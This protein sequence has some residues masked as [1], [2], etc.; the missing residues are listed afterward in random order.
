MY[1]LLVVDDEPLVRRGILAFVDFGRLQIEKV[2]EAANGAEALEIFKREPVDL[3]LA[4]INMPKMNGLELAEAMKKIRPVKI[5]LVTG[6]DYFDYAVKALKTGV[7]DYILKP[8]SRKDI[9]EVLQKLIYASSTDHKQAELEQV[10]EKIRHEA[11]ANDEI[12][13]KAEIQAEIKEHLGDPS[14]SLTVL[15]EHMSL[16]VGYLS[17]LFKKLFGVTFTSYIME[18][19]MERAKI[20]L[21]TTDR[22]NYEIA[23]SLGIEDPNYFSASFK[24]HTGLAP[25][26]YKEKAMK[27]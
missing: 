20:L 21:L 8:V 23:Q 11:G 24:K 19:R 4:D 9:E 22:K 13:Y 5:A 17:G 14:F 18:A 1:R 2:Y 7:D 6:Y 3:V 15:A 12:G 27:R 16:S 10:L 26:A 25:S